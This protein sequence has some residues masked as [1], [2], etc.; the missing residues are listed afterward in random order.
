M[1]KVSLISHTPDPVRVVAEAARCCY[2]RNP[3]E[4]LKDPDKLVRKL[5]RSQHMSPFEHA[6]FQFYIEGISRACSHQLV[7]HR[8]GSYSQRSQRYVSE[9]T[10][11]YVMPP[12]MENAV[13]E[14]QDGTEVFAKDYYSETMKI[15]SER[16]RVLQKALGGKTESSNED[17]RYILPNACTTQLTMT[18][19]ASS[20]HHFF[21]E[22]LCSHAQWEIRSLAGKM[23]ELVKEAAPVLFE[24]AGPRCSLFNCCPSGIPCS[25]YQG[26]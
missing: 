5:F 3:K 26:K 17:A 14:L 21:H 22:R 9:D 7:R 12:Q 11:E 1:M 6:S 16:Y 4:D 19:N 18:M 8:I 23:L 25:L 13:V 24:Q 15:L 20:L 2:S 10:F